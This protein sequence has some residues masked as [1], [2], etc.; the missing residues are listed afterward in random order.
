MKRESGANPERSG[1]CNWG[2]I[3]H[4]ATEETREGGKKQRSKSQETC[5]IRCICSLPEK[6]EV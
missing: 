4:D 3:F 5:L 6:G 1:H 2:V